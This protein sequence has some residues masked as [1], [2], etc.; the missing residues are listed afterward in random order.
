MELRYARNTDEDSPGV[1]LQLE[2]EAMSW[3][4][5]MG[6]NFTDASLVSLHS[7]FF[8]CSGTFLV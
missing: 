1:D 8:I 4:I 6:Q 3:T 7:Q 2:S 5:D